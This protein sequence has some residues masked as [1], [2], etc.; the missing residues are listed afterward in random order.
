MIEVDP[1]PWVA[2]PPGLAQL[3]DEPDFRVSCGVQARRAQQPGPHLEAGSVDRALQELMMM[4]VS[5]ERLGRRAA[6]PSRRGRDL[7]AAAE[8]EFSE[9][10]DAVAAPV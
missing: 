6:Q 2:G 9:R 1:V 3:E 5:G 4:P 7:F 10:H 8:S